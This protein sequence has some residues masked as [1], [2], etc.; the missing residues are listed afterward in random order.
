MFVW[1]AELKYLEIAGEKSASNGL[2]RNLYNNR[3]NSI[4]FTEF[5]VYMA[6]LRMRRL[7]KL[8]FRQTGDHVSFLHL[9][10]LFFCF[11]SVVNLN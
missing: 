2:G 6:L 11:T 5:S 8:V 3:S 7:G 9:K 4:Q 1:F 10:I